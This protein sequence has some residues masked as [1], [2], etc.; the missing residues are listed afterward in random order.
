MEHLP[1]LVYT[2]LQRKLTIWI[3]EIVLV[4]FFDKNEI[5]LKILNVSE[6][7]QTFEKI[8]AISFRCK[9]TSKLQLFIIWKLGK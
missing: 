7:L 2:S 6:K 1:Q 3:S 9:K 4:K 5:K 8:S